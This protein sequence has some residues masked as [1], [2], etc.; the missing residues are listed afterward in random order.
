ML[1]GH[2]DNPKEQEITRGE[3]Y[4][5]LRPDRVAMQDA[6]AQVSRF[7]EPYLKGSHVCFFVCLFTCL[8]A[9]CLDGHAPIHQQRATKGEEII[10]FVLSTVLKS[11][12]CII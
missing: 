7:I 8:H 2:L 4:L 1:Y 3:S 6:T 9:C 12:V 5:Q 11:G 10:A